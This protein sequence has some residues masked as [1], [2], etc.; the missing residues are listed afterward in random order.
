MVSGRADGS[1]GSRTGW[2]QPLAG[3]QSRLHPSGLI[4]S[5]MA[6]ISPICCIVACQYGRWAFIRYSGE[7]GA[8][9]PVSCVI[10]SIRRRSSLSTASVSA[11]KQ[12]KAPVA[13]VAPGWDVLVF[14][15]EAVS[16]AFRRP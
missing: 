2:A 3:S 4:N 6:D 11:S 1:F 8:I 9:S 5:T 10:C 15:R 14:R 16:T 13:A 7:A 12:S